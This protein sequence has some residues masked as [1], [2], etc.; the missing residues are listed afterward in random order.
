MADNRI[1]WG[2]ESTQPARFSHLALHPF[3]GLNSLLSP[4]R[5]KLMALNGP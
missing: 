3:F 4:G 1:E 5:A 2:E